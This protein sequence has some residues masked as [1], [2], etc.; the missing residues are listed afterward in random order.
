MN[1]EVE[2]QST[3]ERRRYPRHRLSLAARVDTASR[4]RMA[5]TQDIS[6]SGALLLVAGRFY[7]GEDIDLVV[8]PLN[9]DE[10][11]RLHGRVVRMEEKKTS[12]PW[13]CSIAVNFE[14]PLP[15]ENKL[16]SPV[17]M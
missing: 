3:L 16:L 1:S 4:S 9:S 10:E 6:R 12:R 14:S 11:I 5:V 13:R 15:L 17:L 2:L 7:Q 8:L